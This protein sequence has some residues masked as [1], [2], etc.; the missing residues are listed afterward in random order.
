MIFN[1]WGQIV[2][3]TKDVNEGWD[4]GVNSRGVESTEHT[5]TVYVYIIK[6]YDV[7][8]DYHEYNGKLTLIR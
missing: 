4:G 3:E 5:S 7:N 6:L 2:F 1:R 8:G